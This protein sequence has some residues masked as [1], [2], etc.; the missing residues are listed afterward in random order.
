MKA[1]SA[2]LGKTETTRKLFLSQGVLQEP[3][4][5]T[6]NVTFWKLR[7]QRLLARCGRHENKTHLDMRWCH[8]PRIQYSG[9]DSLCR[10]VEE[11]AGHRLAYERE[12]PHCTTCYTLPI[13][14]KETNFRQLEQKS[15]IE[16]LL[17]VTA[18]KKGKIVKLKQTKWRNLLQMV[19]LDSGSDD[20]VA[21]VQNPNLLRM[22]AR[23]VRGRTVMGLGVLR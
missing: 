15:K 1:F 18:D 14:S 17:H 13:H 7:L 20:L 22:G 8:R 2:V 4:D 3:E 12:H 11:R 21:I 23:E 16:N 5:G 6:Q 10:C 19:I 9:R